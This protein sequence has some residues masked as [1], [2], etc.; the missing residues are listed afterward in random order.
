MSLYV[1]KIEKS[2]LFYKYISVLEIYIV[3]RFRN[4]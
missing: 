1:S 2:R 4:I 3:F